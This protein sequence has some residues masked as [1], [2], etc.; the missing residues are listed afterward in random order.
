MGTTSC[1]PSRRKALRMYFSPVYW[2]DKRL[3]PRRW[4]F[5]GDEF[6]E[7][8]PSFQEPLIPQQHH[9]GRI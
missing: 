8:M 9:G 7:E 6:F 3:F 1:L 2:L 4:R 5:T